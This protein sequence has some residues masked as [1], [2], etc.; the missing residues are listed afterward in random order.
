MII[1][2]SLAPFEFSFSAVE[3][4]FRVHEAIVN[5]F[6][7]GFLKIAGHFVTFIILGGIFTVV[8]ERSSSP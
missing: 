1:A 8:N 6:D 3:F 4:R 7:R 2:Y 5:S